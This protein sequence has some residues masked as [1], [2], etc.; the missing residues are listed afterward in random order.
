MVTG[1]ARPVSMSAST[2]PAGRGAA[3]F[4]TNV[5][6]VAVNI[7]GAVANVAKEAGAVP[8]AIKNT[9][10]FLAAGLPDILNSVMR[11]YLNDPI[12]VLWASRA[13]NNLSKSNKLKLAMLDSGV[14]DTMLG[15][16]EKY[17]TRPDV[18]EWANLAKESLTAEKLE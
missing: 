18:L 6:N 1:G 16:L 3:S 10:R 8:K 5:T 11:A 4:V 17:S 9:S 15:V 2:A 13:V 7:G 12:L 14:L